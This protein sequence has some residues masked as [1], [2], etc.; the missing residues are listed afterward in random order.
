MNAVQSAPSIRIASAP[1]PCFESTPA[2]PGTRAFLHLLEAF[3]ASGGTAPGDAMSEMMKDHRRGD[4]VTLARLIVSRQVFGFGW[5]G[6]LWLPMFQFDPADLSVAFAP[7]AVRLELPDA[8]DGWAV[9]CWF[10]EPHEVLGG[11]LPVDLVGNDLRAV[12]DA[13]RAT[14]ARLRT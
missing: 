9:A 5:R 13:A 1:P 8:L 11:H 7:Q 2:A 4:L 10:A 12:R 14:C 6:S 3:R